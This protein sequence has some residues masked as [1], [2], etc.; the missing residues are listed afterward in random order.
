MFPYYKL[1][2]H[3]SIL[4]FRICFYVMYIDGSRTHNG[5]RSFTSRG[6]QLN[7]NAKKSFSTAKLPTHRRWKRKTL[8]FVAV[9]TL[10]NTLGC[11]SENFP[12]I[13]TSI[14]AESWIKT[15]ILF[16]PFQFP[17]SKLK[18][19]RGKFPQTAPVCSCQLINISGLNQSTMSGT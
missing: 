5:S 2:K 19:F 15:A 18:L 12:S 3:V 6:R 10:V 13:S 17:E 8:F 14:T 7:K 11:E 4:L 9:S 1:L 16:T